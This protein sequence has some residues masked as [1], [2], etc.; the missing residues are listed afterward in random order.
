MMVSSFSASLEQEE[1]VFVETGGDA[2]DFVV[3]DYRLAFWPGGGCFEAAQDF[4]FGERGV[5]QG[6]GYDSFG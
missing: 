5:A 6:F 2:P 4:R 3:H 1:A